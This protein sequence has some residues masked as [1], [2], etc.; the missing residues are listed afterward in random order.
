MKSLKFD[1]NLA[2]LIVSGKKSATWRIDDDKDLRVD[3]EIAI[4][5]KVNPQK[6]SSWRIIGTGKINSVIEKRLGEID[7]ND[8]E[9]HEEYRYKEEMI[10]AFRH[11][12]GSQ[13]NETTP[14]KIVEFS[15]NPGYSQL[16]DDALGVVESSITELK[17][18][19]DGGSRGNPGPSASGF[20]ITDMHDV[21]LEKDGL[22]LGITTNNQAEYHALRLALER[23]LALKAENVHVFMD[24]LLV[25]NQM[26]G[27][28]K[29]KN[30]ELIPVYKEIKQ[31]VGRF[32][33]VSFTHIPREL[34]KKADA[35]VNEVL[36]STDL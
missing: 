16:M 25:V 11:F 31:T 18:Y 15:F 34:N 8:Y 36:D 9:G 2:Q 21:L 20:V 10:T 27:L 35:M 6:A 32:K 17:I 3:D 19:A 12:Y 5:D 1:H 33:E 23:A 30:T 28:F 26:K 7:E 13:V 22:Y 14:V 29:V 24:S 4:V